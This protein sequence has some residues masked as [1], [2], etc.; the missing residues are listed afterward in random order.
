[1][2]VILV[3]D[4]MGVI[5]LLDYMGVIIVL[6]LHVCEFVAGFTWMRVEC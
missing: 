1:M 4:Y 3:L 2:G 5:L 6:D